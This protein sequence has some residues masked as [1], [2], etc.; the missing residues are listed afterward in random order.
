LYDFL[1]KKIRPDFKGISKSIS[2][3]DFFG[4]VFFYL[5]SLLRGILTGIPLLK[6][7]FIFVGRGTKFFYK[8]NISFGKKV[9]IGNYC[10]MSGMGQE[11]L[12]IGDFSSIGSFCRVVTSTDRKNPGLYIKIGKNVGI[13]DFSSLGGSGGLTIGDDTIIAQYFSAH[14][15]NHIF[16]DLNKPI[17]LQGTTRSTITIGNNCWIGAK[18]TVVAGVNIG[19]GAIIGAGSVVTKDIPAYSIAVGNPAKIIRSRKV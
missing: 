1:I 7:N 3:T 2:L 9:K 4:E 16:D 13:A 5:I 6:L 15:E 12:V 10:I 14:P 11:G 18:V 8:R 19:D 17:R